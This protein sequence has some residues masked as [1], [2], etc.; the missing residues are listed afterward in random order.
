MLLQRS[1]RHINC[2]GC[3]ARSSCEPPANFGMR[4]GQRRAQL[5]IMQEVLRRSIRHT[6]FRH[7]CAKQ[8][9]SH[10][11]ALCDVELNRAL[12]KLLHRCIRQINCSG[13]FT[14]G[15]C[16]PGC[17]ARSS[18]E[19]MSNTTACSATSSFMKLPHRERPFTT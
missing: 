11:R 7:N 5:T 13:C 8:H 14:R 9:G 1:T 17:L 19:P 10:N 15:S 12:E 4:T 3:L 16:E 6:N 2:R 18:C